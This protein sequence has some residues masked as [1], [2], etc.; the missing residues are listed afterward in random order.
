VRLQ[1]PAPDLHEEPQRLF[2]PIGDSPNPPGRPWVTFGLIAVN[3]LVY[4]ALL[5]QSFR[6]ASRDDPTFGEYL[7]AV[8]EER[9]LGLP[10]LRQLAGEVS[11]YD[12]VVFRHGF[13]PASP[14]PTD[15]LTSMFLHGGLM[16]LVGNMLFLWIYGDNV[17]HRLGRLG[18][19]AAYVG[20]GALASAGDGLLRFG[21]SIPSV[22]ASGAISGVLGMYF[23]WFPRNRVRV[24]VFLF[25]LFVDLL[26][27]PS[28]VVIGF[29]LVVDNLLPLVLTAGES[30]VSYGAH[31]GGFAAGV[32]VAT[33]V[34]RALLLRPE[35]ALRECRTAR[36]K[37]DLGLAL[38]AQGQPR[39]ALAA[40]QRV[41]ADHP[42]DP[43][44]AAAH[45]GAARVLMGPLASPTAAYQHIHGA[46]EESGSAAELAEA[47]ALY[48][49]LS[50]RVRSVPRR[51]WS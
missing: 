30:G 9:H 24:W 46:I 12:L 2:L 11:A 40:F 35:P 34:S 36:D 8:A 51:Y 37:L 1:S 15:V 18:F 25:P 50:G 17:E 33:L 26:E 27:L 16:H 7:E 13:R 42:R 44:R 41:L 45:M 29:F 38:E 49:E 47:Q 10:E 23:L 43:A 28:R 6:A 3:V 14:S 22:G 32:G 19:L 5:P 4:L 48:D 39:S 20:T 31:I 21:S